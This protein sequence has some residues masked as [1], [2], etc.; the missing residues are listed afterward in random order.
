MHKFG[1]H[2]SIKFEKKF[3]LSEDLM[4]VILTFT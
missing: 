3:Q 1:K 2:I 4:K